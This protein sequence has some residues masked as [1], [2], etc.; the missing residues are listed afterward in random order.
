M[1]TLG[2]RTH[3]CVPIV[4]WVL[5]GLPQCVCIAEQRSP[6]MHGS[7]LYAGGWRMQVLKYSFIVLRAD[8]NGQGASLPFAAHELACRQGIPVRVSHIHL[9]MGDWHALT[10]G[11]AFA[12]FSLLKR[13]AGLGTAGRTAALD[14]MLTQYSTGPV[15][16]GVSTTSSRTLRQRASSIHGQG[17][18]YA[19]GP[20]PA[21]RPG[22]GGLTAGQ[23]TSGA[24]RHDWR[25]RLIAVCAVSAQAQLRVRR[26]MHV[27]S[28]A[29]EGLRAIC[30]GQ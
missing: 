16:S 25:Q 17:S 29:C 22:P 12:L 18:G 27:Q 3:T 26:I 21:A 14:R 19:Q 7:A 24:H 6:P 20:S 23:R 13:Q 9:E 4:I 15:R 10:A 28:N 11:G 30:P 1:T 2:H 8:D 5:A